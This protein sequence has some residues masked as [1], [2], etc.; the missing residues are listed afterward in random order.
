MAVS[1]P[2]KN[3][4]KK[5]CMEGGQQVHSILYNDIVQE[6]RRR[7]QWEYS[8]LLYM[9]GIYTEKLRQRRSLKFRTVGQDTC[10]GTN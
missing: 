9:V 8:G 3:K 10:T 7:L 6:Q 2:M 5:Q 1:Q 4:I